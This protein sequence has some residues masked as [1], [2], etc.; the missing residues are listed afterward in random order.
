MKLLFV[1]AGN[2]CRSPLAEVIMKKEIKR[3][4]VDWIRVGSAGISARE[5]L[6]AAE[7]AR[8]VAKNLGSSLE[9]FKSKELTSNRAKSADLILTMTGQQKRMVVEKWPELRSKTMTISEFSGSRRRSI[10]DPLGGSIDVYMDCAK[11]LSDE[12]R[13]ILK[14][15]LTWHNSEI[16]G[17]GLS[18]SSI[19]RRKSIGGK[20][21]FRK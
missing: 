9:R 16:K 11:V 6:P 2:T 17:S 7:N 14:K 15:L 5:G 19:G 4:N 1:C 12:V 18:R 13:R 20:R 10:E 3:R 21:G 8:I